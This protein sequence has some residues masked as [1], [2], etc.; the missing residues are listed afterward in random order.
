MANKSAA[1]L[2][3]EGTK[4]KDLFAKVK[5]KQHNFAM[6]ISKDGVAVEAHVKK[7]ASILVK[8]AKKN[9]GTA[10]GAWGVMTMNGQVI[11]LD[12]ENDKV[13]GSLAKLAKKYFAER[14]LKFRVEV[15][16]P[17]DDA[18]DTKESSADAGGGDDDKKT[19]AKRKELS[20]KFK[21]MGGDLK[22]ALGSKNKSEAKKL[23]VMIKGFAKDIKGKDMD[24]SEENL[25]KLSD[26]TALCMEEE[27]EMMMSKSGGTGKDKKIE[28]SQKQR[29]AI[30]T[31]LSKMEK[32]LA[33]MTK[34]LA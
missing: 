23:A 24:Q 8:M 11:V 26:Q 30:M 18:G 20:K 34:S 28:L 22:K 1:E 3:E 7:P 27:E 4:L 13:P 12:P 10:K 15:K 9:G 19:D 5:K 6:L 14:G 16:E 2:K 29:K 32:E 25:N 21:A 31:D 33:E 17:D